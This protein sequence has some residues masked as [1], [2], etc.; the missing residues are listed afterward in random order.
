MLYATRYVLCES[1]PLPI[2]GFS[3]SL[4]TSVLPMLPTAYCNKCHYAISLR[5]RSGLVWHFHRL[6]QQLPRLP[7]LLPGL[8]RVG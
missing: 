8:V 7:A 6:R 4:I 3:I 5:F 2:T 1:R